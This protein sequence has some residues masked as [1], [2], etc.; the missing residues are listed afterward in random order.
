MIGSRDAALRKLNVIESG[1][2]PGGAEEEMEANNENNGVQANSDSVP[3]HST[4]K[5]LWTRAVSFHRLSQSSAVKS[6][7]VSSAKLK[8]DPSHVRVIIKMH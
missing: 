2:W 4:N 7:V 8:M 1:P 5:R 6:M 3:S